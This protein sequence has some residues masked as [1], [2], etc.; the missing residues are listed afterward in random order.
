MK[1]IRYPA[2]ETWSEILQRPTLDTKFLER[3]VANIL[4]DVRDN[5]DA[6]LRRCARHF[7]KVEL[8]AVE[9]PQLAV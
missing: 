5:G 7:E 8:N 2:K 4:A 1:I 9:P 6:A 3:T